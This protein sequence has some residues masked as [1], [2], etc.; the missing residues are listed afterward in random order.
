MADG[1]WPFETHFGLINSVKLFHTYYSVWLQFVD[2]IL[3]TLNFGRK[4]HLNF[5]ILRNVPNLTWHLISKNLIYFWAIL[6]YFRA[7]I[8]SNRLVCH[9]H[10]FIYRNMFY[11][12]FRR[13]NRIR[14]SQ[15]FHRYSTTSFVTDYILTLF[16][17]KRSRGYVTK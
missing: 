11:I 4:A 7:S 8:N 5:V 14:L 13:I 17:L 10:G 12:L 3:K 15:L 16:D 1:N 2:A 9:C 6:K